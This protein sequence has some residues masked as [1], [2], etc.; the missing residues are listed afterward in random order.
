MNATD[1]KDSKNA[2]TLVVTD[3]THVIRLDPATDHL[4]KQAA[5]RGRSNPDRKASP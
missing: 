1:P 4:I 2:P 5:K 3:E